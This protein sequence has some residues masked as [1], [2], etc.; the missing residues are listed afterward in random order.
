MAVFNTSLLAVDVKAQDRLREWFSKRGNLDNVVITS[1][2]LGDSDV[3]Y[4]MSQQATR[5]KVI[6]APYQTPKIKHHLYYKGVT[7]NITGTITTFLRRV[8][9]LDEVESLYSYP[10]NN[11]TFESGIVPPELVNGYNFLTINFDIGSI[12]K[13]GFIVYN[14]TLPT[15]FVDDNGIQQRVVEQY[16]FTF[17]DIPGSWEVIVDSTNG[18]FLIAKPAAYTFQSLQGSII[19][20][21]ASSGLQKII[22]YNY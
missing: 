11:T 13:E 4:N 18:S 1:V 15:N 21:G 20:K 2:G 7:S 17:N 5:I 19:V 8:N 16:D 22:L 10:P 9:E 6:Q 14:Q 3:D 12:V